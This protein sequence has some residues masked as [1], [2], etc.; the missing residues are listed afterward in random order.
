MTSIAQCLQTKL[1]KKPTVIKNQ[2]FQDKIQVFLRKRFDSRSDLTDE[3][4]HMFCK[5]LREIC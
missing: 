2:S 5:I 1:L 4:N 3:G